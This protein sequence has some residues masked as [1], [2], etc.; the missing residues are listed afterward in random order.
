MGNSIQKGSLDMSRYQKEGSVQDTPTLT[1]DV[2]QNM[3]DINDRVLCKDITSVVRQMSPANQLEILKRIN[4]QPDWFTFI[5]F[6]EWS[7]NQEKVNIIHTKI[8]NSSLD[9]EIVALRQSNLQPNPKNSWFILTNLLL[10]VMDMEHRLDFFQSLSTKNIYLNADRSLTILNPYFRDSHLQ[11]ILE[12][13]VIP[14][15]N[16]PGWRE[17]FGQSY[18]ARMAAIDSNKQLADLH[19]IHQNYVK[20]MLRAVGVIVLA[21]LMRR[22]ESGYYTNNRLANVKVNLKYDL[23]SND[24]NFL[25]QGGADPDLIDLLEY[26]LKYEPTSAV[27]LGKFLNEAQYNKMLTC[28]RDATILCSDPKILREL[29]L[30]I[31]GFNQYD[32]KFKHRIP[33]KGRTSQSV[34]A[35]PHGANKLPPGFLDADPSFNYNPFSALGPPKTNTTTESPLGAPATNLAPAQEISALKE[36]FIGNKKTGEALPKKID[37]LN[38]YTLDKKQR[39]KPVAEKVDFLKMFMN[40]PGS[41]EPTLTMPPPPPTVSLPSLSCGCQR[42]CSC[43]HMHLTHM[44]HHRAPGHLHLH[45]DNPLYSPYSHLYYMGTPLT[46]READLLHANPVPSR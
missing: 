4:S 13:V 12:D 46:G 21:F 39:S 24:L 30:D 32:P 8:S 9:K 28:M 16:C 17:E 11:K 45:Y 22:D 5:K 26:I 20:D 37:F 10:A 34:T 33:I 1:I 31:K 2:L 42:V 27:E 29:F 14:A 38:S 40:K 7:Q 35:A 41:P 15:K 18:Y 36:W 44:H 25:D 43:S 23:I 3:Q 6:D 19:Y